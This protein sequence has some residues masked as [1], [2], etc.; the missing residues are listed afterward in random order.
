MREAGAVATGK[1]HEG[2]P[3]GAALAR[4]LAR[5]AGRLGA[6][7]V[8]EAVRERALRLL[9]DGV[10]IG[11]ASHRF[12]FAAPALAAGRALGSGE[13]PSSVIGAPLRLPMR[14][15]AMVNGVLVHGLDYDDTHLPGV[16]HP[17]AS[18][19]PALLALG[20]HLGGEGRAVTGAELV[21]AYVAALECATRVASAPRGGFHHR[22]FHP[23]GLVGAFGCAI[24]AARLLGLDE[25]GWL[26][27][28]LEGRMEAR[29]VGG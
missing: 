29:T 13:G 22:G 18:L 1:V 16:I 14:D 26:L 10:G 20:E 27:G 15:A 4:A 8:P 2:E 9:L 12:D 24:G 6:D 5:F 21:T 25:A 7:A 3:A 11:L 28:W 23:T 17:T 19:L